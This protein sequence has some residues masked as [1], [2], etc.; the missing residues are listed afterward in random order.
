MDLEG[1]REGGKKND[2]EKER[3]RE[4]ERIE[5]GKRYRSGRE[6]MKGTI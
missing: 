5:G 2:I 3:W 1:K 4:R 6:G